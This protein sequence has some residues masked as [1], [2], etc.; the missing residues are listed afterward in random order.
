MPSA[1][2]IKAGAAYVELFV[3]DNALIR[4]LKRASAR[5][6]RF[7]ATV[8]ATGMSMV[9]LAAVTAAP[10]ALAVKSFA[11]FDDQ[12]RLVAAVT[13]STGKEFEALT[14]KAKELGR[15]TSFTA[16]E[17]AAGMVA[18]GRAGFKAN[19][20]LAS[21]ADMMNL[22][23][24]TGTEL[25][26]AADIAGAALRGFGL[27]VSDA[28]RVADVL[29]TA[30]NG[31]AQTLTELGESMKYVAPIAR[32]AGAEIEDVAANLA[33][34]ANNGIKGSMAGTALARAY[35][36]LGAGKGAATIREL[37]VAVADGSGDLRDL[38][39]IIVEIGDKMQ[40]M[41]TA[42]KLAVW[43]ELFGRGSAAAAALANSSKGIDDFRKIL[44]NAGGNASRVAKDM[45][46]GLGG[47]LRRLWSAIEGIGLAIGE[48]LD[49]PLRK[50]GA[51][52]TKW[53]G[54]V[55]E[56]IEK[57]KGVI[58]TV[59]KM[60]AIIGGLGVALVIIGGILGVAGAALGGIVA[61]FTALGTIVG[62]A[63]VALAAILSPIGLV[64]TGVIALG[65]AI[66]KWTG[67]GG[68][69]ISWLGEKFAGLRERFGKTIG[70]IGKALASGD[71]SLAARVLW[72]AL[73]VEWEKGTR[74][75]LELWLGAKHAILRTWYALKANILEV[76]EK[77]THGITIA[78]IE[79]RAAVKQIWTVFSGWFR[80]THEKAINWLAKKIT[81]L[82]AAFD[83]S[84]D[85]DAIVKEMDRTSKRNL[86]NIKAE[87][88]ASLEASEKERAALRRGA[89]EK[90]AA[91]MKGIEDEFS[92]K[93]KA[94]QTEYDTRID[95]AE[96]S[97]ASAQQAWK[98]A[99]AEADLGPAESMKGYGKEEKED[100]VKKAAKALARIADDVIK[101]SEKATAVGMFD[102]GRIAG[103]AAAPA[104]ETAKNTALLVRQNKRLIRI[105]SSGGSYT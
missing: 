30:A 21:T 74:K 54:I 42:R 67:A 64:I 17:V 77:I 51:T 22:A 102:A 92:T 68:K 12:M 93:S 43:E 85:A 14:A 29:S 36:N 34:M 71:I 76:M 80:S 69:A 47:T 31:S 7:G 38:S 63:G 61:G 57:N 11:D 82:Q 89:K 13:G 10:L 75:L 66:L 60:I 39:T 52:I 24:S 23:R 1:R 46:A 83:S 20:I 86:E 59:A 53:I 33:V 103:L 78:W 45:D 32:V 18:L 96:A 4:G 16:S 56:W 40:G 90:H 50:V 25:A 100:P 35:K 87:R 91:E 58:W 48:A 28:G 81:R 97:L 8:K 84:I 6:K 62:I 94:L 15:T 101:V 49:K 2:A 105:V 55:T 72:S 104:E 44:A 73:K 41:G 5:L 98:D 88:D 27:D 99:L 95:A 70:A 37:G 26:E 19:E 79:A 65:T 3:K 9:K